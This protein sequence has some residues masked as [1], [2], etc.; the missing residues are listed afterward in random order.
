MK[1][2]RIAVLLIFGAAIGLSP[3][4]G[5]DDK[6]V[7]I[8]QSGMQPTI[9]AGRP[10][11]SWWD[12][13]IRGNT[14]VEGRIEF[15]LKNES[16]L[17]ASVMTEDLALMGPQ[18]RIRVLL[19]PVT[20]QAPIDQLQLHAR[21][22]GKRF[23]LDLGD[24][25]LRVATSK[26]KNFMVLMAVSRLVPKR[27]AERNWI[28]KRLRFESLSDD[29]DEYVNTVQTPLE[30]ADL[31]QEPMA[32]CAYEMV[33]LFGDE[34]RQ[35]KKPQLDALGAWI[36]AGGSLYLE[37]TGVLEPYHVEFLRGLAQSGPEGLVIQ[38]DSSGRLIPG[39]IWDDE[40]ILK[41][42]S[43]LGRIVLRVDEPQN[44][45][46]QATAQWR[47][48]VAFLWRL[49]S[50]QVS[51]VASQ[52][53][54]FVSSLVPNNTLNFAG[55]GLQS[56]GR[57]IAPTRT[58]TAELLDWLMPEGV[59]MVPLSVLGLILVTFVI[60]IGPID[61]FGLGWL[62]ARKLT[63]VTFPLATILVTALT[64]VITN[65]YMSSAE[66]RRG[67]VIRDIGDDGS[68]VRTNRFELLFIAS[69]REV[70]TEM[71]KGLFAVLGPGRSMNDLQNQPMFNRSRRGN[72]N[73]MGVSRIDKA[74]PRIQGRIPTEFT[75]AQDVAKW[76]PQL[77]RMFWIPGSKDE[78]AV[79]WKALLE[80]IPV[81]QMLASRYVGPELAGRVERQFGPDA[82]VA[83]LG[84]KGQWAYSRRDKWMSKNGSHLDPR[85]RMYD[86]D[87][88]GKRPLEIATEADLFR[89]IYEH[90]VA[91]PEG[92]FSLTAYVGPKGGED[93]DD[94]Q[95]L[96]ATDPS[97]VLLIVVAPQGDDII[98]E[99]KLIRLDE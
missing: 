30:P 13:K 86:E 8:E 20:D 80:G 62:K 93:L 63:W 15:Q 95:I 36:R 29:L 72:N 24:H 33:V 5:A 96:D 18:Q 27:S 78:K 79:D 66:T 60:W 40:R 41:L 87:F 61:Y 84:M 88:Y 54:K 76:T 51:K 64:V 6:Q 70:S 16:R 28:I 1:S 91:T 56:G 59:R 25:L 75:V 69:S 50:D 9:Q 71:R 53:P 26:S 43:G 92:V 82:V 42:T 48:A 97:Q 10:I 83:C 37:P 99:R 39:T 49:H 67:M 52:Q 77:N 38:P 85:M 94:L 45:D 68:V 46:M 19:P 14:L 34:F 73:S 2:S 23:N 32:Y 31:P 17:L 58:S 65:R 35:L 47:E 81:Q 21:F 55:M 57:F 90:S 12:V 44:E 22:L 74:P 3:V 11:P 7:Q 98:V 4:A 89:W